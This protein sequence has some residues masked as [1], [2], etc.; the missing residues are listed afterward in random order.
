MACALR[1][2]APGIFLL[3]SIIHIYWALGGNLG[4]T[5]AIPEVD[6]KPIFNPT[7]MPTL[8]VAVLMFLPSDL[9]FRLPH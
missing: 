9:N 7:P 5:F 6:G 1:I 4:K 8:G 2:L 3:L